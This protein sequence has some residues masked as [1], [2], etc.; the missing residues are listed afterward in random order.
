MPGVDPL[1]FPRHYAAY[2]TTIVRELA[3][4]PK[5]NSE[6]PLKPYVYA[7]PLARG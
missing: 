3:L 7:N 6:P 4:Y 5:V 2:D 1:T